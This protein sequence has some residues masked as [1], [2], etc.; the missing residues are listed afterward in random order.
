MNKLVLIL[1]INSLFAEK[2]TINRL[3]ANSDYWQHSKSSNNIIYKI[4]FAEVNISLNLV[5]GIFPENV[6]IV[7]HKGQTSAYICFIDH[8]SECVMADIYYKT[9]ISEIIPINSKIIDH[10]GENI[11]RNTYGD[12]LL[13]PC[14]NNCLNLRLQN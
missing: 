6:E 8:N 14:D 12:W 7:H 2:Y 4:K 13:Q 11:S 1:L 9:P 3:R 5:A 10:F